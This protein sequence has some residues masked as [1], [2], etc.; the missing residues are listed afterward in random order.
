MIVFLFSPDTIATDPFLLTP[1]T[2]LTVTEGDTFTLPCIAADNQAV[3]WTYEGQ[4]MFNSTDFGT[5]IVDNVS[6]SIISVGRSANGML[7]C[8][9]V[10]GETTVTNIAVSGERCW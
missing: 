1:P 3:N 2:S 9:T 8:T 7:V 5:V 10:A 4:G 6:I